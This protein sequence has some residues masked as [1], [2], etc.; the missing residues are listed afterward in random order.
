MAPWPALRRCQNPSAQGEWT[1][2]HGNTTPALRLAGGSDPGEA[3]MRIRDADVQGWEKGGQPRGGAQSSELVFTEHRHTP[4]YVPSRAEHS[5]VQMGKRTDQQVTAGLAVW[6]RGAQ[7]KGIYEVLYA[8]EDLC[9]GMQSSWGWEVRRGSPGEVSCKP[10]WGGLTS[11]PASAPV[12]AVW[13]PRPC[14]PQFPAVHEQ[15][16][17]LS[18]PGAPPALLFASPPQP[19]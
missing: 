11:L 3:V 12:S 1:G 17:L 9:L 4:R 5:S 16:V 10:S 18:S 6:Y 2:E 13:S 14:C 8:S 15:L 7:N 19:S